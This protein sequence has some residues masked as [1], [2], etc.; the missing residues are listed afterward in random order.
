MRKVS[1]VDPADQWEDNVWPL[2]QLE[3]WDISTD[4]PY[5]RVLNFEVNE[6][7]WLRLDVHPKSGDIVFDLL[8]DIYCLP[9]GSSAQSSLGSPISAIPVLLGV[10]HDA[11]P[12]FSPD[13][14]LLAF[15]SDAELGVDN[16]WVTKWA[17]CKA[18][19]VRN[20][21]DNTEL[22][23]ALESKQAE[24]DLL[25]GG[26]KE[27]AERKKTRLLREGRLNA[28]RVTNETYRF[29]SEPRFHP[30]SGKILA[31]KWYTSERSLGA[32]EG[33]EYPLP[34]PDARIKVGSG[35]RLVGRTLPSGWDASQYGDQQIGPEQHIWHGEDAVVYSKNVVD[36]GEYTYS[37]D[38]HKG[39]YAIFERN[40]TTGADKTLVGATPGGAS[41]PELSR[42]GRTLAFVR[43]VRDK[44]ALVIKDLHT[45]TLRHI[46][47]GL[48]Y[49]LT[50]ISAPMGTYPS[51]AFTPADDAIII[52]AA[53]KIVRVPLAKN[54]R[55][56]RVSGGEPTIIHFTAKVEQ[57]IADTLHVD[58][59]DLVGLE[60]Q[61][62]MRVCAL[63]QLRADASGDRV[64]FQAAGMTY[65]QEVVG[66]NDRAPHAQA[67]PVLHKES[68]YFSPSFV[69]NAEH[70]VV[71][72]R[73]S[74]VNFTSF[75]LADLSTQTAFAFSGLP[76]GRYHSPTAC[77][78][79]GNK[80][81]L[82]FIKTA[83][84]WL[85]GNVVA[86][87][88][89]GLYA[90]EIELPE[91]LKEGTTIELQNVRFVTDQVDGDDASLQLR[92]LDGGNKKLLVQQSRETFILDLSSVADQKTGKLVIHDLA[93]GRMSRQL[94]VSPPTHKGKNLKPK[95][96]AFNEFNHVYA[97]LAEDMNG[98]V[99]S[100]PG[101]ATK[102]VARLSLDGG[103]DI[104]WSRN[105]KK[106]F[107]L[108]GPYLHSLEI[109]KLHKCHSAIEKDELTFGISCTKKLLEY[110]EVTVEHS[111]DVTRLRKEAS[112]HTSGLGHPS[113]STLLAIT[114]ASLL[115]ME[116]NSPSDL[117]ENGALFVRNGVI[118]NVVH[119]DQAIV[120]EN[121][122]V[123]DAEGGYVIPGFIDMHAHWNGFQTPYPARSW[124]LETFLAYGVT[125]L[126]NPS[127]SQVA[128]FAERSR[129]ERGQVVGPRIFHTGEPIYGAGDP[130]YYTSVANME[131]AYSALV[132]IKA[133]GGPASFSY[134]NYNQPS[135][136]SRQMLLLAARKLGMICVPEGGMN[137][138]WDL[139]Y[140]ADGMTTVE[141]ALPVPVLYD[142]IIQFYAQ[143]GTAAVPTHI[144]NYGGSWGEQLVWATVDVPNESKLRRFTRHDIL[145]TLTE[146]TARPKHS[147]QLY[148][149]SASVAK[150]VEK[151]LRAHIG[152]HGEPPLGL[153][154]HSE[155]LFTKQG[156][157]TNYETIRAATIDAAITLGLHTSIG[158]LSANKLA[159]FLIYP[160]GID[161]LNDPIPVTDNIKYVVRG[162]RVWDASTMTEVWP[163]KGKRPPMPPINAE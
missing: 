43:R 28:W 47:D 122:H 54:S 163:V 102:G 6:G 12:R 57:R 135:R 25:A 14:S 1:A 75:E 140:I 156:G 31:T 73:W 128:T 154:Y 88:N 139:T 110:Q 158:S 80:R 63:Q 69:P 131:E 26:V 143:S 105:G 41:R 144:V 87:A 61:K 127:A 45:G 65:V 92:F 137:L 33:W 160:P 81:T 56:E 112:P 17:G 106:L 133:E 141:H 27:T 130:G 152:A 157:L 91:T 151:G 13:G 97:A 78:C 117:I 10:P 108:L 24:E 36:D 116:T 50:V 2:R 53:G 19:D 49:D 114:N 74:D 124:E 8:G 40:L 145:E 29:V 48:T 107:W 129:V 37:K 51:F 44:E 34:T 119:R 113:D 5:K 147:Y 103:H 16:I 30:T 70:L 20:A 4:F 153:N 96:V 89:P 134:K 39:I 123:I 118:E 52:W 71:H 32:G 68:P 138:G 42:D 23:K 99:W 38:V 58:A 100:K 136:A 64:V 21:E 148:N 146:S 104:T 72:A 62:F 150:M 66:K 9:H 125:T 126:H 82:A 132:R 35:K 142:D 120:L 79:S 90:A 46:Y 94:V 18:M 95:W 55:G 84:D 101:N 159:D 115:T 7:T 67:L 83:G 59:I 3:P 161:L 155:M 11:D 85:T 149:T 86:T 60:T 22:R 111:T 162:G 93:Q 76:L 15:R 77:D 98:P 109:A 121:S